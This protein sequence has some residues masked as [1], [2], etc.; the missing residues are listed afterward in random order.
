MAKVDEVLGRCAPAAL[1]V[2]GDARLVVRL[3]RNPTTTRR[4]PERRIRTTSGWLDE[5]PTAM[6]PSTLARSTARASEPCSGEMNCSARP[7]RSAS[8]ATPAAN[9]AWYGLLNV[10]VEGLGRQDPERAGPSLRQRACDR[11]RAIAHGRR[12]V[13]DVGDRVATQAV[14]RVECEGHGGLGH[15]SG[16]RH[17]RDGGAAHR[18]LHELL[19]PRSATS[20]LAPARPDG[21]MRGINGL[22]NRF[23]DGSNGGGPLSIRWR[24]ATLQGPSDGP[25]TEHT[26]L[27]LRHV[28]KVDEG[29]HEIACQLRP[30]R[31]RA[32]TRGRGRRSA[33]A[34]HARP[35]R[36]ATAPCRPRGRPRTRHRRRGP[37][38]SR[39]RVPTG[40]PSRSVTRRPRRSPR[41]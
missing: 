32:G 39:R 28:L 15:A 26:R 6:I 13:M 17:I 30:A 2:D 29:R 10:E 12:D 27:L 4:I 34:P 5:R 3:G 38:P 18:R 16:L 14:G 41:R 31:P 40:S 36:A 11:V 19:R 24:N 9:R 33:R 1:V 25:D 20:P 8:A 23:S 21:S 37:R 35:G 22:A 7:A